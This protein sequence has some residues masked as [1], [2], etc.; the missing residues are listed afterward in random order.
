ME[1]KQADENFNLT[2]VPIS[3]DSMFVG[4][5]GTKQQK[6]KQAQA[7][8][9]AQKLKTKVTMAKIQNVH[10]TPGDEECED[11]DEVTTHLRGGDHL[12]EHFTKVNHNSDDDD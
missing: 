11:E 2:N 1:S 8:L 10:T 7:P 9:A 6:K 4:L 5:W 12:T 3:H